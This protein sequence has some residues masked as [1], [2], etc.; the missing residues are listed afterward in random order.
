MWYLSPVDVTTLIIQDAQ[1]K[2]RVFQ[3]KQARLELESLLSKRD[4]IMAQGVMYKLIQAESQENIKDTETEIAHLEKERK[5]AAR[6]NHKKKVEQVSQNIE[7]Y[8]DDKARLEEKLQDASSHL[9]GISTSLGMVDTRLKK[10]QPS[11]KL[12]KIDE[13][14]TRRKAT[15]D[16]AFG[17]DSMD[18]IQFDSRGKY[19]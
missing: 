8:W 9:D 12:D 10:L 7:S 19:Q 4:V 6:K 18:G 3:E 16:K 13:R 5:T 17:S 15:M 14:Y 11:L 2:Q 1:K